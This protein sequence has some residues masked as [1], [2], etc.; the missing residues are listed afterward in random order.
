MVKRA[1]K[2]NGAPAAIG[3]Y[4]QG[5]KASNLIFT[6]G[7]TP[8]VPGTMELIDGSVEEATARCLDNIMAVLEAGGASMD[9]VVKCVVF[10]TDM[11]DFAAMNGVYAS[12]FG[13][14]A[15][16]R[17]CVQVAGLPKG[18]RVEIEAIA[19]VAQFYPSPDH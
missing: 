6:S 17:S 8:L 19:A 1:I 15:P 9:D 11:N 13:E 2:T 16:A 3:P 7:Q 5:I 14:T 4:S 12:Y 18:A 10:L